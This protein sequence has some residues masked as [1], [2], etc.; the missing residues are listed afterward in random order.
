MRLKMPTKKLKYGNNKVTYDLM[1]QTLSS[2]ISKPEDL[3]TFDSYLEYNTYSEIIRVVKPAWVQIHKPMFI[4]EESKYFPPLTWCV[5]FTLNLPN[6][7]LYVE[8]KGVVDESFKTRIRALDLLKPNTLD[9]LIV[10]AQEKRKI[11]GHGKNSLY[12][13]PLTELYATLTKLIKQHS[14]V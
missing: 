1:Q 2:P 11:C 13:V 5:D 7:E 10:V 6:G 3:V 4:H 12:S 8:A 14:S 9:K